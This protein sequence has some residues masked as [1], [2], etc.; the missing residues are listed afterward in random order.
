MA[1]K[2]FKAAWVQFSDSDWAL[3]QARC[4]SECRK[5]TQVIRSA[6]MFYARYGQWALTTAQIA[7]NNKTL[8]LPVAMKMTE[9]K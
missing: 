8:T 4:L 6:A 2:G 3:L 9:D 1:P 5:P 7:Q